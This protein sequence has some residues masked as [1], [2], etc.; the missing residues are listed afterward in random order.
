MEQDG[1]HTVRDGPG[2]VTMHDPT[3]ITLNA[4]YDDSRAYAIIS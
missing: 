2:D 1:A 4:I 3:S